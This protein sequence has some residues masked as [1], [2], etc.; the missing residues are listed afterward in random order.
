ME[1]SN[2]FLEFLSLSNHYFLN[3]AHINY[4][5]MLVFVNIR[6]QRIKIEYQQKQ[7]T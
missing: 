5:I 7:L 3:R 1:N 2:L 6:I 4:N